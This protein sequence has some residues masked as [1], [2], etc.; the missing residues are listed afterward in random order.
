MGAVLIERWLGGGDAL[1]IRDDADVAVA[2]AAARD[3]AAAAGLD[4]LR[5][6]RLAVVV[7][8]LARN[9]L[10]HA[11]AGAIACRP[12][13]RG[14]V[15]G[16]EVV[17]ADRGAGIAD[18]TSA[19]A[20][21][22]RVSGSLGVGLSVVLRQADEV[23]FDVRW[24][25]GTCVRARVFASAVA[26]SEVAILGAPDPGE[27]VSGDD[28]IAERDGTHLLVSVIDGL[29]HGPHARDAALRAVD[30]LGRPP[31]PSVPELLARCH[32]TVAGSRGA[33]AS[34]A[35]VDLAS[36]RCEH[37]GVGNVMTRLY[38][39]DG[40]VRVLV[41][42]AGTLGTGRLSRRLVGE[43][44]PFA[45]PRLLVMVSDGITSRLDLSRDPALL[46]RHPLV[47]AHRV[48][49]NHGRGNDDTTVLVA[50]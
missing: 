12:V 40:K 6:E 13:A 44:L 27:A 24:G 43:E 2:R 18:P 49:T 23:D 45:P 41:T 28:A 36:G 34:V 48:V 17:A 50:R 15:A 47:I 1:P 30:G 31:W 11:H 8:E 16:L 35:R 39:G 29:G 26:R 20:G 5:G 14:E 42:L 4:A 38:D 22:P 32:V 3:A 9:Q 10:R 21:V 7:S 33:V 37:A 46:Q 19:L 25:A